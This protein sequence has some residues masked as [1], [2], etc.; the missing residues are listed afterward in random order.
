MIEESETGSSSQIIFVTSSWERRGAL[1]SIVAQYVAWKIKIGWKKVKT[2]ALES[3]KWFW[4]S[5]LYS[6]LRLMKGIAKSK[7]ISN[8]HICPPPRSSWF[9]ASGPQKKIKSSLTHSSSRADW[10]C[11]GCSMALVRGC[12]RAQ[13][14]IASLCISSLSLCFSALF[15]GCIL[16]VCDRSFWRR[17]QL[18]TACER[19]LFADSKN[20]NFGICFPGKFSCYWRSFQQDEECF[21][22]RRCKVPNWSF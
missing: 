16:H 21:F 4:P 22:F 19:Y 11:P 18:R 1:E 5:F 8:Q 15:L 6:L 17:R 2:W 14:L 20:R 3:A 9:V 13:V 10:S 7:S 12:V